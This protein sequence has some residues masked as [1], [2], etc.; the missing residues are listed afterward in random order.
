MT[1]V[2]TSDNGVGFEREFEAPESGRTCCLRAREGD[3]LWRLRANT[4]QHTDN[5]AAWNVWD[6]SEGDVC[7]SRC[8][9]L[10]LCTYGNRPQGEPAGKRR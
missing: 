6:E 3:L 5:D 8:W 9:Y 10:L 1:T 7:T 2:A 4:P